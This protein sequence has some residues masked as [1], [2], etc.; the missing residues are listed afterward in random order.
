MALLKIQARHLRKESAD[1]NFAGDF[2]KFQK[3]VFDLCKD[4]DNENGRAREP[5]RKQVRLQADAS[6]PTA[7]AE[8]DIQSDQVPKLE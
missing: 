7:N 4:S 3:N 1:R 2:R 8:Q 6:M 5:K